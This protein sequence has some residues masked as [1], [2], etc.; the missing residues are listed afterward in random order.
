MARN[1]FRGFIVIALL[2]CFFIPCCFTAFAQEI[3]LKYLSRD[4]LEQLK[5]DISLEIKLHH[6]V[7]SEVEKEV[8]SSVKEATEAYYSKQGKEISW[9]WHGWEYSYARDRDQIFLN[10]HT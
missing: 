9:A 8:L 10:T 4:D 3:S 2:L 7:S 6:E 5:Q 1:H